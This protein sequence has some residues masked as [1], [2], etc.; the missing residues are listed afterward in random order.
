MESRN[1]GK[2]VAWQCG[3]RDKATLKKLLK[4]LK[5]Y[6]IDRYCSDKWDSYSKVIPKDKL[7]QS[8]KETV[9]IE[10]N[11]SRNRHW[12]A[13]FKRKSIVVSKSLEMVNLTMSLFQKFRNKAKEALTQLRNQVVS[14]FT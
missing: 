6:V 3:N 7:I 9:E 13:R 14:L 5:G 4:K 10:R 11:N 1:T 12:F 2:L 8:K